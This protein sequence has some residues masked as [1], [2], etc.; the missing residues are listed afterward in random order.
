MTPLHSQDILRHDRNRA[1][2]SVRPVCGRANQDPDADPGDV[3]TGEIEPLAVE[4]ASQNQ[5]RNE[6]CDDRECCLSVALEDAVRQMTDKKNER[7][8]EW[9]DVTGIQ[10][11]ARAARQ[12]GMRHDGFSGSLQVAAYLHVSLILLTWFITGLLTV[13]FFPDGQ[14][15]STFSTRG[16]FPSPKCN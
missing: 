15:I 12:F 16:F 3:C 2:Q 7:D 1:A 11:Q 10:T 5:L 8:E 13:C 14:R 9:R 6:C 4:N